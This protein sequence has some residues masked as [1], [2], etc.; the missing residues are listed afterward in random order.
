MLNDG[1]PVKLCTEWRQHMVVTAFQELGIKGLDVGFPY[2]SSFEVSRKD[3]ENVQ[4][5]MQRS[6]LT[7]STALD[8]I[9]H[10]PESVVA[11]Q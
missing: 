9:R 7:F 6:L 8:H 10:Q 4:N 1:S 11:C 5:E 3:D 2:H